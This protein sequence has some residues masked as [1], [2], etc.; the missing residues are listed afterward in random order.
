MS[1][2]SYEKRI[3][4]LGHVGQFHDLGIY[5]LHYVGPLNKVGISVYYPYVQAELRNPD[6]AILPKRCARITF[7]PENIRRKHYSSHYYAL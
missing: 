4:L 3:T 6:G 7:H 1:Y 5:Q 2:I